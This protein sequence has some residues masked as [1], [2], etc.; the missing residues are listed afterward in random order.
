MIR[1]GSV[2]ADIGT[3][4]AYIPVYLTMAGISPYAVAADINK[5]PLE[6][7]RINAEK[8]GVADKMRF[9]LADGLHGIEPER[10]NVRDIVICG[11]GGELIARIVGESDYTRNPDVHLILQPMSCPDDLRTFLASSGYKILD[12]RMCSAVGR[13]YTCILAAYTGESYELTPAEKLLG[14][15]NIRHR[16]ELFERYL[17]QQIARLNIRIAGM[18]R[19]GTD[20]ADELALLREMEELKG[21][22]T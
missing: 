5:G 19:G 17:D 2:I 1:H 4:H 3:D 12:E 16:E 6:R 10:D 21:N 22:R 14:P 9:A 20:P 15:V 18:E 7:A 13:I 8:Y 11:M